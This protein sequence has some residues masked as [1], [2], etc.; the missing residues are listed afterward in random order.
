MSKY[1]FGMMLAEKFGLDCS[2]IKKILLR[3]VKHLSP[4]PLEMSLSNSLLKEKIGDCIPPLG[5]SFS[6]LKEQELEGRVELLRR[7]VTPGFWKVDQ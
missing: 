7:A 5:D 4:R 1:E 3:D 6:R 2:L